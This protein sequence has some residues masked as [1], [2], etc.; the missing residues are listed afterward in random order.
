MTWKTWHMRQWLMY[1]LG[2][3]PRP[4]TF[5]LVLEV[6]KNAIL[7]LL[8]IRMETYVSHFLW[9]KVRFILSDCIG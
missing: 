9:R 8:E 5:E 7:K 3:N 1:V 6:Y 4:C 2:G